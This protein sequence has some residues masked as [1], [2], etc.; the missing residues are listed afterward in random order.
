VTYRK[1][2]LNLI[3]TIFNAINGER[4]RQRYTN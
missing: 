3:F 2:L 4:L 1:Q